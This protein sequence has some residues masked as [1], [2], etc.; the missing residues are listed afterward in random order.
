MY[1]VVAGCNGLVQGFAVDAQATCKRAAAASRSAL[2]A[3]QKV[4]AAACALLAL[5]TAER[6]RLL[7]VCAGAVED[8]GC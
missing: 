8:C 5:T 7:S 6:V 1:I 4:S 3:A 2:K